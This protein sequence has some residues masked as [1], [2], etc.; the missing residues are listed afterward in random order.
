VFAGAILMAMTSGCGLSAYEEQLEREQ[1]RLD[2]IDDANKILDEPIEPLKL[3]G[4]SSNVPGGDTVALFF[5][6]PLGIAPTPEANLRADILHQ[7]VPLVGFAARLRGRRPD[8]QTPFLRVLVAA[9][10]AQ[11]FAQFASQV[12]QAFAG[13]VPS[14]D[15]TVTK[16]PVDGRP[17]I[18]FQTRSFTE[19]A[20]EPNKPASVYHVYFYQGQQYHVAIAYQVPQDK[21]TANDVTKAIDAS[22]GS[23]AVGPDAAVKKSDWQRGH[24]PPPEKKQR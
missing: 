18:T 9:V 4:A 12:Q 2:R 22:L 20:S 23:L 10:P 6:P 5:R 16:E 17:S 13:S 14:Q 19:A 21:A 24:P 7:Y 15:N 1:K 3:K 8:I 11:D